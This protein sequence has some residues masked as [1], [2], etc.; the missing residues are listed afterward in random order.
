M[1]RVGDPATQTALELSGL[2]EKL[3]I[4][5]EWANISGGPKTL[6]AF[7][8]D[9]IDVGAVADIPPLFAQW[10]GTDVKIV[11]ARNTVDPLDHPTY[12]L[13]VAPGVDVKALGRPE[14]QEDRV[15]PRTGPGRAGAARP[16]GGRPDPGRRRAGRDD[17]RR[18]LLRRWRSPRTRSTS[19]RSARRWRRPT[20][21]STSATARTTIAPGV[22]DDAWTLYA[23]TTV[24][25]DAHKA[26][27]IKKYV[28]VWAKAQQWINE[29]PEEFAKAL[30]RGPRG[31][32]ARGRGVR[33][34]GARA[35]SRC[36]PTG[37]TSIARHQET[38]DLL[39]KE[40]GHDELDVGRPLRPPLRE[41]HRGG[42]VMT[43]VQERP[44]QRA[45]ASADGRRARRTPPAR[46]GTPDPVRVLD[47]PA[48]ARRLC[49]ASAPRPASSTRGRSPSRGR[50]SSSARVL[51][52][53]GR[54]QES[55]MTSAVRAL[56]GLAI[57]VVVGTVLAVVAGLSRIGESLVDGPVQIKRSIPSLALIP[58]LILW[59]GIGE[60]MKVI[61][62]ALGVLV[63]VYIHTHNGLRSIDGQV[64]RA[65]RDRRRQ[66]DRVRPQRRAA[67]R[68]ARLPA[69]PALR[70]DL[71][72]ARAGRGRADQLHERDRPHDHARVQLRAD[73]RDHR[74]PGR[75]RR[76][77]PAWP[78]GPSD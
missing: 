71:G 38:A 69:G 9:A 66:P 53:N 2:D 47:R 33:R 61:T 29:H 37:T 12:E 60:E 70:G 43:A 23:P 31:S 6:E 50:W 13:G 75:V 16:R 32:V 68:A 57:G 73:R 41:G 48:R 30:L 24:V 4:E 26:A 17:Q 62:I 39:A 44:G 72:A 10:T 63:P 58:L 11:A 42:A 1:L 19:R 49:G 14:G 20:S 51:I 54:L 78:T 36:R 27:A 3:G 76:P 40:Q 7:R 21:R 46:A 5:V 18:R 59:F 28:A 8:A 15:Q 65:R 45:P 35:R 77:R 52:E 67:R 34:E 55:L 56:L 25:E 64:R 22:R 74:R